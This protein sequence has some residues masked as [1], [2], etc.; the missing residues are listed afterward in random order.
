MNSVVFSKNPAG[1]GFCSVLLVFNMD[2]KL[3]LFMFKFLVGTQDQEIA[4]LLGV[5]CFNLL[6]VLT[7]HLLSTGRSQF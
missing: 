7:I 6:D 2:E 5:L 4:D 3:F 1:E